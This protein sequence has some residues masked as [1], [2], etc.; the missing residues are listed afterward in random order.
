MIR[1]FLASCVAFLL[2]GCAV[3]PPAVAPDPVV[4]YKTRVID[5]ACDWASVITVTKD[6][7]TEQKSAAILAVIAAS[8]QQKTLTSKQILVSAIAQTQQDW[9]TDPTAKMIQSHD[10]AWLAKCK[11]NK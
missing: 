8:A 4:T 3:Q 9:L 6:T 10:A 1:I 11:T 7:L 5:T 2:A